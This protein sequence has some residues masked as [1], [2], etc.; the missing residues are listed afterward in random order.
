MDADRRRRSGGGRVRV[1]GVGDIGVPAVRVR[2]RRIPRSCSS[3]T[4]A[5]RRRRPFWFLACRYLVSCPRDSLTKA[6]DGG[7]DLV[8]GL[9]PDKGLGVAVLHVD[10][11][12]E[13][14]LQFEGAAMG[15]ATK[16]PVGEL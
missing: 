14:A 13:G 11:V 3:P 1:R 16:L 6:L 7:E 15:A 9:S 4:P 10:V 12:A 5:S 2:W 8:S